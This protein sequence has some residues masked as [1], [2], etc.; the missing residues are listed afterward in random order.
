MIELVVGGSQVNLSK[1]INLTLINYNPLFDPNNNRGM[2]TYDID[3]NLHDPRNA[4]IYKHINKINSSK[5]LTG[6]TAVLYE[7]GKEIIKGKEVILE[8][9]SSAVK[10][11]ILSENSEMNIEFS[12]KRI[13]ELNLGTINATSLTATQSAYGDIE[14][15]DRD[16][17]CAPIMLEQKSDPTY[18]GY[19]DVCA[20]M[21]SITNLWKDN[22]QGVALGEIIPQPFVL[23]VLR[24]VQNDSDKWSISDAPW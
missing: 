8:S 12:N 15:T 23:Y 14:F 4:R 17:V 10:I 21:Q 5:V 2:Y 20:N 3:I 24:K 13:A 18:T 9:S 6:R 1:E 16:W 19:I 11:Q 22:V 7:K